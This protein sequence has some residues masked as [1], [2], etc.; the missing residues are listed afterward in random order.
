MQNTNPY[1]EEPQVANGLRNPNKFTI[2]QHVFPRSCI[3]RFC[4]GDARVQAHIFSLA[5]VQRL[6]PKSAWFCAQRVWDQAAELLAA[7][8]ETAYD[9]IA[10]RVVAGDIKTLTP[11]MDS[12]V[13]NF[14]W[15]WCARCEVRRSPPPPGALAGLLSGTPLSKEAQEALE[16]NGYV[17]SVDSTIPSR[18]M[19]GLRIRFSATQAGRRWRGT[20]WG[21]LKSKDAEFLVPDHA[22]NCAF[23]PVSP[24]ICLAMNNDDRWLDPM[25]VGQVNR[26][27]AEFSERYYFARD[28]ERSPI[29]RRTIPRDMT[30]CS[31]SN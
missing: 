23:M 11:E 20:H 18:F 21:I 7:A 22:G 16:K 17:F 9:R 28:I 2:D 25:Q 29:H 4:D 10:R 19:A 31:G 5:K 8:T 26:L 27:S 15:L 24:N 13:T 30:P 1:F 14:F 12:V 6:S 3:A